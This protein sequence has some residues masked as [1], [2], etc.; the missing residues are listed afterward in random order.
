[1]DER[2][3]A[4]PLKSSR[5]KHGSGPSH[6]LTSTKNSEVLIQVQRKKEHLVCRRGYYHRIVHFHDFPT[7]MKEKQNQHFHELFLQPNDLP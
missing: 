5:P 3:E 1:M 7:K 2:K 6:L 4:L